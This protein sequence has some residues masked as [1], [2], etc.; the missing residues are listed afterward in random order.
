RVE[1]GR[2]DEPRLAVPG[3]VL[4]GGE[5]VPEV[6]RVVAAGIRR[7]VFEFEVEGIGAHAH[8]PAEGPWLGDVMHRPEV[9]SVVGGCQVGH[10]GLRGFE[11]RTGIPGW[12]R[13]R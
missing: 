13:W 3:F 6:A 7:A 8:Q 11:V 10:G 1:R 2:G 9:S 4:A 12:R 5:V